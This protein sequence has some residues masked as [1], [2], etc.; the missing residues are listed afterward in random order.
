MIVEDGRLAEQ[1]EPQ[2]I[3]KWE[4]L[5]QN[6]FDLVDA[7]RIAVGLFSEGA[8]SVTIERL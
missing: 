4:A 2:Y 5:T 1:R 8:D 3:I 6:A 7:M